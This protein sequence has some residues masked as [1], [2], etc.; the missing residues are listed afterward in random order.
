MPEAGA[1]DARAKELGDW[2]SR[3]RKKRGLSRPEA[4]NEALKHDP[5]ASISSD[6]LAKLEYGVRSLASASADNRE[7]LRLALNISREAWETETGLLVPAR[8]AGD[9]A[10]SPA[11]WNGSP[12]PPVVAPMEVEVEVPRELQQLIDQYGHQP[13]YEALK[14]RKTVQILAVRRAYMGEEDALQTVEDWRDY[15]LDMRRWLPK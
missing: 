11:N 13:G 8:H 9:H 14:N 5:R 4:V 7:A 15:F 6:Y 1:K 3:W 12:I 2:L 10:S